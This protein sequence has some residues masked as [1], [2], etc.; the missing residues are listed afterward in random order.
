MVKRLTLRNEN[1]I[2]P[3]AKGFAF[4]DDIQNENLQTLSAVMLNPFVTEN[5]K[6]SDSK[7]ADSFDCIHESVKVLVIVDLRQLGD[8]IVS[9]GKRLGELHC[10]KW[11]ESVESASTTNTN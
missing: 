6:D 3:E 11:E 4:G 5:C 2:T 7:D 9:R 10:R 1:L 8:Q